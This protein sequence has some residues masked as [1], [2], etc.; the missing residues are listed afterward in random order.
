MFQLSQYVE[1]TLR[2]ALAERKKEKVPCDT[3]EL[4]IAFDS[5]SLMGGDVV[6]NLNVDYANWS[7]AGHTYHSDLFQ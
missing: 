3:C 7:F 5:I 6:D 4:T 2:K 1:M